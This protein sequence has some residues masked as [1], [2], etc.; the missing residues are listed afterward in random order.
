[1]ASSFSQVVLTSLPVSSEVAPRGLSCEQ[2]CKLGN[3][4]EAFT[5]LMVLE[6]K[7]MVGCLTSTYPSIQDHG[8]LP[9]KHVSQAFAQKLALVL[10]SLV[11]TFF[12]LKKEKLWVRPPVLAA[13]LFQTNA[14][15][16]L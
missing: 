1:M 2:Q 11:R 8:R 5:L 16:T 10:D 14:E 15:I 9:D 13:V 12:L 4:A 7:I 3:V 6:L